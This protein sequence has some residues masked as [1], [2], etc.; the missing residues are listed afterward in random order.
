MSS[1][2]VC[3]EPFTKLVRKKI[4]CP[5]CNYK[6]CST[7]TQQY[8]LSTPE[9]PH[10][11][12]CKKSWSRLFMTNMFTAKFVNNTYK[13][14]RE[15]VLFQQEKSLMPNTQDDV[16]RVVEERKLNRELAG[17]TVRLDFLQQQINASVPM[18]YEE[19]VVECDLKM[20]HF[21]LRMEIDLLMYKKSILRNGGNVQKERRQFIRACPA[22]GCKGFLSTQWKCGLCDKYTCNECHVLLDGENH[23]CNP[24][25]VATAKLL[26]KDSKPCPNCAAIIYKI[27]GC[28][29]MFCTVCHT[30]F[31]WRTGRIE[32]GRVHNPHYYAYMR[33]RGGGG[34]REIGDIQCGGIPNMRHYYKSP[35]VSKIHRELVHFEM[36]DMPRYTNINIMN[37]NKNLPW[38]VLYMLNE[39]DEAA[40]KQKIQQVD[41]DLNKRLE[42]GQVATT[43]IQVVSDLF[44]KLNTNNNVDQFLNEYEH[45]REYFNREFSDISYSYNCIVPRI[46]YNDTIGT[47]RYTK[48]EMHT[49]IDKP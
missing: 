5:F 19:K 11:M 36:V 2:E 46:D 15:E 1:C 32:T 43:F 20:Q 8:L 22:D 40:F 13:K 29:Q 34:D 3:I 27:D 45:A 14:H 23:E 18:S 35:R 21:Q 38:R 33:S 47:H 12:S 24:A 31:S 26:A 48:Y 6:A 37:P 9:T 10:C 42:I 25:D 41:K 30:A 28:D 4:E 17:K 7:C 16:Q 44:R 39:L 49:D